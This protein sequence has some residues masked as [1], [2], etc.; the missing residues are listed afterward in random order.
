MRESFPGLARGVLIPSS[1]DPPVGRRHSSAPYVPLQEL[2]L[3]RTNPAGEEHSAAH[4]KYRCA[5]RDW[6]GA[7]RAEQG[8]A[9]GPYDTERKGTA[10]MA[11]QT[12]K[13]WSHERTPGFSAGLRDFV[14]LFAVLIS[15]LIWWLIGL[16]G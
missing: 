4:A 16:L 5:L 10:G 6:P 7:I 9:T 14:L 3:A 11:H 1:S 8:L 2:N 15:L 12:G 13:L